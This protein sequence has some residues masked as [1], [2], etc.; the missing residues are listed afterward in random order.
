MAL[1]LLKIAPSRDYEA[2]ILPNYT[3]MMKPLEVGCLPDHDHATTKGGCFRPFKQVKAPSP[4]AQEDSRGWVPRARPTRRQ[5]HF[6]KA[7]VPELLW[8]PHSNYGRAT[9]SGEV[10]DEN[11]VFESTA[12]VTRSARSA[13]FSCEDREKRHKRPTS[14]LPPRV[15]RSH[16]LQSCRASTFHTHIHTTTS[17]HF[18]TVPSPTFLQ[19]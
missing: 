12:E 13:R 5:L 10:H 19:K 4:L 9:S 16:P 14:H 6:I 15:S 8:R 11:K 7:N 1:G 3:D 18:Q 2:K 17:F